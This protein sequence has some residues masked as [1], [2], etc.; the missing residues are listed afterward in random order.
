MTDAGAMECIGEGGAHVVYRVSS[1]VVV[2]VPRDGVE[3]NVVYEEQVAARALGREYLP[4]P[5]RARFGD[6]WGTKMADVTELWLPALEGG[7]TNALEIKLKAADPARSWLIDPE[8]ADLKA[9]SSR[10]EIVRAAKH[11]CAYQ[12]H[13]DLWS[14]DVDEIR[15]ALEGLVTNASEE[16]HLWRYFHDRSRSS[17]VP[18]VALQVAAR[19]LIQEPLRDR[20]RATQ[21]NDFLDVDGVALLLDRHGDS[22]PALPTTTIPQTVVDK[23]QAHPGDFARASPETRT[24]RRRDAL[25]AISSL[26][27]PQ[28]AEALRRW[29]LALVRSVSFN[30]SS[31]P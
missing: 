8:H 22:V 23:C 30:Q 1:G 9:R 13:R 16:G 10:L 29:L 28:A 31:R 21:Q 17:E 18:A 2:R 4:V 3:D 19:V 20:L 5:T 12:G 7:P 11:K 6:K 25:D 24:L 26:S 27:R 14:S 15:K